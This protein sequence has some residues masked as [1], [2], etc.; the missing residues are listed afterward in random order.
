MAA[1]PAHALREV[2]DKTDTAVPG[3]PRGRTR[4]D[5]R[6]LERALRDSVEGEVRFDT[7]SRAMYATDASNFRQVPIGVVI[8]KTLD[9]V[10]ATHQVCHRFAAPVLN[11]GGGTS[12]SGETV[13][14]AVVMDHTK[15]LTGIGEFD[16][17][18]RRVT[19]EPGV[20]NEQLNKFTGK[21]DLVF[22]PDPS[23]HSRCAIGG[24]I[25]NNSCGIHSV[26]SQLYGPGP[27]TSDNVAALEVVTYDGERFWVG[28][29]EESR[30]DEIIAAGGRKGEIYARLRELRDRYADDIRAGFA[31]VTELPRRVSGFNLDEL[32][33]ERGFNVARALVGTESTCVTVLR[34]TLLL[35]PAMRQRTLVVVRY[36]DIVQAA[37]RVTEIIE[38]WRPIALEALDHELIE[39]QQQQHMHV[40]DIE[41]LP[42]G[43]E[44]AWLL[45]QFGADTGDES[46]RQADDFVRWLRK[47]QGIADDRIEIARSAQEGGISEDIWE[48][49]EGGLAGTAFAH[50]RDNWP[51]WEDSAVPPERIGE[52]LAALRAKLSEYGLRGAMYGH[53][54]Q[55][56]VHSRIDFD[57]RSRSGISNYRAFLEDAADLV[58]SFGG[59]ISGEHG[60]GQQRGELLEKQYGPRL[61]QAMREFKASW[62]PE[63]KMNP[64]KVV[65]A[66]PLDEDLRLGADYNPWRP[67][68]KMSFPEERGDFAHA[69]LRCVGIG[70]CRNPEGSPTMCP[71]YQVTREEEHSTRGRAR[72]LFEMLQG[73][74]VTDG[75]QSKEV[76]DALELC[77]ACKG[78]TSD[79]PVKVDVPSYKAEFRKHHYRS[80]RRWR[81][82]HAYAFGF[83]DQASRL[84]TAVPELANLAT[85][86][87][88][89]RTIAKLVAGIDRRRPLPRFAPMTLQ[90]WF[91]ERGG[92]ANPH[93]RPVVLF[94]DTFNNH[95]HTDVGVACVEELEAAGWRV[96]V[97]RGHVCCGRPLYDYGFLDVAERYLHRVLAQL[98][99][100]VR[101]DIPV[102]GMEPSCLAV[103]KDELLRMLPHDDDARRLIANSYHFAEFFRAFDIEPPKSGGTALLWGHCHQRATGGV[104]ADAELLQR[105][106]LQVRNLEGGCCGL[107]GSWGFEDGKYEIS[108]DCGEQALLPAVREADESAVVVANGFSCQT[109]IADADTGRT[110]L[111]LAQVMRRARDGNGAAPG[112]PTPPN[113]R[114]ALRTGV[115][116]AALLGVA[117]TVG[118]GL[119]RAGA[120][121]L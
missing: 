16:P 8:P 116:A 15:Y 94:P 113:A 39:S 31:P 88:G 95:L 84:A 79:C 81:P 52:Y 45:V 65:D 121:R 109:Q 50:G 6:G 55:G 1:T 102:V 103:F 2:P 61:V 68:T 59:S 18:A 51:G 114:R 34:S 54:G 119:A 63:W 5:V 118:V 46:Q 47:K 12:L 41:E 115:T 56:C 29:G 22:G 120:A 17:Q 26:Q 83:I 108:M 21:Q 38:R 19:C 86:T 43:P 77:L 11:R 78:C 110:A 92:T 57:L 37:E 67:S 42:G 104:D 28:I 80:L 23:S 44:G 64:G 40:E 13:N 72:L 74:V 14:Y 71:S 70:K 3:P 48:I 24:N 35:T 107:A 27:R 96:I 58:V 91:S 25:G 7:G 87:P 33:P 73:D 9:D 111:H 69:G 75:W 20:I 10:V 66:Y 53:M 101:A 117:G 62:D 112:R 98:R 82:R 76:A 49:R 97:P 36:D 93:G 85:R 99:E 89:L 4:I 90:Q 105:M 100:Y 106:G 60:D 30:L 32:L